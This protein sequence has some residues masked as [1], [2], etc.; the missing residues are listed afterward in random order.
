M[1]KKKMPRIEVKTL[2]NGY[3]LAIEGH[4]QE[5]M[6]FNPE[7]LVEGI[8]VHIGL[9]LT[10][11]MSKDNIRSFID[12]AMEFDNLKASHK[13]IRNLKRTI[14]E[15]ERQI[16]SIARRVIEERNRNLKLIELSR[17]V[18]IGKHSL[19]DAI[20]ALHGYVHRLGMVKKLTLKE[21]GIKAADI[22]DDDENEDD[23]TA[24]C[25]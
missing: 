7:G 13:E 18:A 15:K 1:R 19:T 20:A 25:D 21:F 14:S 8:M 5:Y 10:D 4:K 17:A 22:I 3:S 24:T 6:Y 23:T 2:P 12:S 9:K 11:Q 16:R